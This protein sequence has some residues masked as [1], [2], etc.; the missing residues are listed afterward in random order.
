MGLNWDRH[1]S[2]SARRALCQKAKVR[3]LADL[4]GPN[5]V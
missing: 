4:S 3:G 1:M 2:V 5:A